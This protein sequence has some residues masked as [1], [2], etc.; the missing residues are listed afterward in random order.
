MYV[1]MYVCVYIYI[2]TYIHIHIHIHIGRN[3]GGSKNRLADVPSLPFEGGIKIT[4]PL[5][6]P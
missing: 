2:Y 4:P 1:C 3:L 5:A 6:H